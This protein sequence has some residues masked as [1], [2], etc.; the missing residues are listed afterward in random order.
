M[1]RQCRKHAGAASILPDSP[2]LHCALLCL[3]ALPRL[4]VHVAL[5]TSGAGGHMSVRAFVSRGLGLGGQ[6]L[7]REFLEVDC[8]VR[9]GEALT[10]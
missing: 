2:L 7:A 5:D 9:G 1:P 6:Q 8:E 4:Q 3:I 10:G